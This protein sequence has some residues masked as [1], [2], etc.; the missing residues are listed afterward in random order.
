MDVYQDQPSLFEVDVAKGCHHG[1]SE[2]SVPFMAAVNPYATVVTSGDNEVY[3]HP[4]AD[5]N[6]YAGRY[7]E[8]ERPLAFSTEL[9]LSVSKEKH[10]RNGRSAV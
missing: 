9:A 2:F 4:R 8:G 6:G 10:L 5:G 7:S 1:A 3:S